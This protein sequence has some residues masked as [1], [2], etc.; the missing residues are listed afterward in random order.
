[1]RQ[2]NTRSSP[3]NDYDHMSPRT[4]PQNKTPIESYY[5]TSQQPK[6]KKEYGMFS[7]RY[8]PKE[9]SSMISRSKVSQNMSTSSNMGLF[10]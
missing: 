3:F 7:K 5:F 2:I 1:M 10:Q 4:Q 9:N 8:L 6:S